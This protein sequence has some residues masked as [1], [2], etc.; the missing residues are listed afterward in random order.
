MKNVL[1]VLV[2]LSSLPLLGLGF[3]AMLSP[4][5]MLDLFD[6]TPKGTYGYN[7]IRADLG[8]LLIGSG[9]MIWIGL[10]K[11]QN[12]WFNATIFLMAILLFGRLLSTLIDGWT[13]AAIPAIGVEIFAIIILTLYKRQDKI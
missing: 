10:L 6:L 8:G 11:T 13:N 3:A 1:K 7:T 5:S 2:A 9:L 12:S 4:N